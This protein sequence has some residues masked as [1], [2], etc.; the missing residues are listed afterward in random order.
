VLNWSTQVSG[1]NLAVMSGGFDRNR[2][3]SLWQG[4]VYENFTIEQMRRPVTL[5]GY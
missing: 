3:E 5:S 2:T 4:N 1:F